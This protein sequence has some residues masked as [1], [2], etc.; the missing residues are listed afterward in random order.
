[1]INDYFK[2]EHTNKKFNEYRNEINTK[3]TTF[4][5]SQ[6]IKNSIIMDFRTFYTRIKKEI[7]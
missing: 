6:K 4:K 5:K 7:E 3:N 1:M 2:I